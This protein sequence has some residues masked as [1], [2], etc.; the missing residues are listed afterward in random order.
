M[1]DFAKTCYCAW[2][3]VKFRRGFRNRTQETCSATHA[4]KMTEWRSKRR[5]RTPQPCPASY[6]KMALELRG[7]AIQAARSRGIHF[8]EC[9]CGKFHLTSTPNNISIQALGILQSKEAS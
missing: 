2:C 1:T 3:G 5:G 8:Y 9:R 4:R 6:Q 7:A